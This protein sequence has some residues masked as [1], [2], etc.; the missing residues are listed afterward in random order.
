MNMVLHFLTRHWQAFGLEPFGPPTDL[1]CVMATPRFRASSHVIFFILAAKQSTPI[2]VVK[3]PRLPG[4]HARL[5]LEATNLKRVHNVRMGGFTSI[6]RLIAYE[7]YAEHR[8][9]IETAMP[10]ETMS[11]RLRSEL[12]EPYVQ[13]AT[14][15]LIELHQATAKPRISDAH[16]YD[17]LLGNLAQ[18]FVASV[19]LSSEELRRV[20]QTELLIRGIRAGRIPQ[21]FEHGDLGPVNIMVTK[22][23]ELGVVDWELAE[24]GGLPAVD[25]FFLLTL[26]S[27]AW[28]RAK[29]GS[30]Y[31]TA[32]HETFFG[33]KAWARP[34]IK[35]YVASMALAPEL[36][37]PLFVLC[38][39]RYVMRLVTR[40]HDVEDA[41]QGLGDETLGWLRSN[42]YYAL[43]Q[44]TVEHINELNL[45]D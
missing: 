1:A 24:P 44:H 18:Q 34:Y 35:R 33:P 10:G 19:P 31:V 14:D 40:L 29:R 16:W 39:S 21:V 17:D 22:T 37:N 25:L 9:L 32:F 38:W 8:L 11:F 7:D 4:D 5:D 26:A 13:A 20:E 3:A 28:R 45:I 42:R 15:W 2:L 30:D 6:P 27:P 41:Q 23:G 36:L 43:W 12:A